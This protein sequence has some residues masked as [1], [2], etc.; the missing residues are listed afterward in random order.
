VR[1]RRREGQFRNGGD[2]F[3]SHRCA[4]PRTDISPISERNNI[5]LR[6]A[7]SAAAGILSN[8]DCGDDK[9]DD[10][11]EDNNII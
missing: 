6:T 3:E 11:D 9:E 8:D 10:D 4:P 7:A 5:V 2:G 1:G